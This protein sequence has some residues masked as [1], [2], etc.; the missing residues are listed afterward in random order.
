MAQLEALQVGVMFWTGGELGVEASPDDI[1]SSVT[2][3][4]V[5]CGQI[6]IHGG[7]DIGP[8]AQ[9]AWKDAFA[10]HGLTV[11]TA[12]PAFKGESYADVETVQKTVGYLP[13][14]T[15][16]E[17]EKRT[18]ASSDF[19]KGVGVSGLATHIG[20]VPEDS[21]H[22]DYIAIRDMVR[23]ICDYCAKNGQSFALETGQEPAPVLKE[24]IEDVN[25]PNLRVNFDPANM[26][27]YGSGEPLP[28][29]EVVKE[30]VETVH[31][32]DG[33]WPKA[34]GTLGSE[35]PLGKGDVGMDRFVA[36]LK[37]IGYTGPLTIEREIVGEAQRA[38]IKEA[39]ALLEGLRK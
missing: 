34:K 10:K 20:Y 8:A 12:F 5:S 35:A 39:I 32:K 2:S 3:L 17:R 9:K 4:G 18:Y 11:V 6:G 37:E 30:W 28:A 29:L 19:A 16:E 1:V 24:F 13:P 25:K 38:D 15:R 14:A 22:P 21:S 33:T 23:R 26:I 7:A 36:K 31:C 27:L